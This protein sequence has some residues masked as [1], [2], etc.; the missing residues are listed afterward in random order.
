MVEGRPSAGPANSNELW[1]EQH[2]QYLDQENALFPVLPLYLGGEITER[3]EALLSK[4]GNVRNEG[5]RQI[6]S[7]MQTAFPVIDRSLWQRYVRYFQE[8]GFLPLP[9]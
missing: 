4:L 1:R 7:E 6:L 8:S 9:R 2:L 3:H 5:T